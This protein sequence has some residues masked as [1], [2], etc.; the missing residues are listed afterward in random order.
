MQ[1][2]QRRAHLVLWLL[3]GAMVVVTFVK[4]LDDQP[5][6]APSSEDAPVQ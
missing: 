2:W 3:V 4:L 5:E 1:R 6:L